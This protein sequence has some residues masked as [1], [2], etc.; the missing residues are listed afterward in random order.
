MRVALAIMMGAFGVR[1]ASHGFHDNHKRSM[2]VF[3][4]M[5]ARTQRNLSPPVAPKPVLI[6]G[7]DPFGGDA[8][9]P[10]WLTAQALHGRIIAG[11]R[12]IA[13]QLPTVFGASLTVLRTLVRQHQPALVLCLG[14]AAGRSAI[15]IERVAINVNDARIADNAG[16][17]PV[18]EPVVAGAPAAYFS[19]LPIKAMQ[20]SITSGGVPAEV[21]QT[22]GTFVCN[23]VFFGLMHL[24]A[25]GR[26]LKATRGGFIHLPLLPE[27]GVPNMPLKE[28][29]EGIRIGIR[30]ALTTNTDARL[31][32]GT[33][34]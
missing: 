16:E 4:V 30:V 9:N 17:Q 21:S 33:I 19:S 29:V 23:Q 34:S 15:S 5:V 24:L 6:T 3:K 12:V 31:G 25:T 18:D 28:M 11:H 13:A 8:L 32:A 14:L 20:A 26:G 2:A 10:S 27:Q 22:A 1:K 7:F